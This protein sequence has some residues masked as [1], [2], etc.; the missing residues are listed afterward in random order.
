MNNNVLII[1]GEP[2]GDI[3]AAKVLKELTGLM[4]G[5]HFW[6]VGGDNLAKQGLELIEHVRELS[7]VGIFEIIKKLPTIHSQFKLITSEIDKRKPAAAILVDYPGFNLK[8]AE[9]LRKK[10]IPV[11]YYIIP[12]IWAWGPWRIN[13]IKKFVNKAIVLFDFEKKLL[14]EN[15]IDSDFAGHP[16]VDSYYNFI[17][18]H[19][20]AERTD[21]TIALLPGSRNTEIDKLLPIMLEAADKMLSEK[22]GLKFIVAESS[23][24]DPE[25]YKALYANHSKLPLTTRTDDALSVLQNCDFAFVTS[26]TAT[27]ETAMMET[28]MIVTYKTN[29]LTYLLGKHIFML[30]DHLSLANIL[31]GKEIVPELLQYNA[32]GDSMSEAA[33]KI[34]NDPSI[35]E[36]TK[37]NLKKVKESLGQKG[38]SRRVAEAIQKYLAG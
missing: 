10:N 24:I 38:A 4:P 37:N 22:P 14:Q 25:K 27:L 31:A 18:T 1:T 21:T 12:Q 8:I 30:P 28:P 2:S 13:K 9:Y 26:G 3:H 17:E 33:M 36:E 23:N 7:I 32:T 6:G 29:F 11:I 16:L 20:P 15:G 34:M 35:I 5:T 19:S